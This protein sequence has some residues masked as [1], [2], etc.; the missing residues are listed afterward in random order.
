MVV[1]AKDNTHPAGKAGFVVNNLAG[2]TVESLFDDFVMTG[3][4][5]KDGGHWNPKA[6]PQQQP[7]EPQGKLATTW[8][9]VK[10]GR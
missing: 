8:G 2:G 10:R 6:H 7:V 5:V 4:E 1:K 3:P 9:K